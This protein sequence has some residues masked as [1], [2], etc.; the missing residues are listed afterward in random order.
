MFDTN[1]TRNFKIAAEKLDV[2]LNVIFWI[3]MVFNILFSGTESMDHY[4][5]MINSL[6]IAMH[7]PLFSTALPGNVILYLGKTIPIV[8][9]DIIK[10][11][12]IINPTNHFKF[13]DE[14]NQLRTDDPRFA[15]QIGDI[16]YDTHNFLNNVGSVYIFFTIYLIR[17]FM[18]GILK[19]WT[20][21]F[22]SG[23]E[24]Y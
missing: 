15:A 21:C 8:M 24:L 6:Q 9:F 5:L 12:W 19:L 18:V 1:A 4:V 20:L 17:V 23:H 16:G 10:E 2:V 22:N 14:N 13:D 3:M 7:V 11:E